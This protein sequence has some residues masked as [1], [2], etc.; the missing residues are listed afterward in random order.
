MGTTAYR[1]RKRPEKHSNSIH[2][3]HKKI[4]KTTLQLIAE[5]FSTCNSENA[6]IRSLKNIG[7]CTRRS[8]SSKAEHKKLSSCSYRKNLKN[9]Q[10][11]KV[12]NLPQFGG[13]C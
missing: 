3:R 7:A 6:A 2:I 9:S 10:N 11:K 4:S 12:G 5:I 13:F 1:P 8:L